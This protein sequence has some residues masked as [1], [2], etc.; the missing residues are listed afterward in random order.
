MNEL[1][2]RIKDISEI[3]SLMERSSKFLS[4]SG[5]AGVSA[6]L[7]ALAGA[8]AAYIRLGNMTGALEEK[9]HFSFLLLDAGIVLV[10]ALGLAVFFT[11][12]MARK[13]GLPVWSNTTKYMLANL[14][15]PLCTGGFFCVILWYHGLTALIS[16]ATLVF[17]GLALLNTSNQTLR[18]VRY[19]G[20]AEIF[21]GLLAALFLAYWLLF[22]AFG[23]GIMHVVYGIFMYLKYEQ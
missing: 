5:L 8:G 23:F 11:R 6:G 21:L 2:N 20:L 14:L 16:P 10:L 9:N 18:E 19:L 15:L 22:W 12:R 4:L 13:K 3:R 17:Y 7:V 1:E